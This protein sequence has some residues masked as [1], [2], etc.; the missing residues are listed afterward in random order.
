MP[1][2][3]RLRVF[4]VNLRCNFYTKEIIESTLKLSEIF[5][6]NEDELPIL[7]QLLNL[8][9]NPDD[10]YQSLRSGY[11]ID[12]LI[13]TKGSIGSLVYLNEEKSEL[14]SQKVTVVDTVGAGDSFTATL[15][16]SLVKGMTL[17]QAHELAVRVSGFVCTCKGAMAKLPE[18]LTKAVA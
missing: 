17:R 14:P 13:F 7:A 4:D 1:E 5:K 9:D 2:N 3:L 10:F 16:T 12:G 18:E 8:P 11:A 15:I 6:C